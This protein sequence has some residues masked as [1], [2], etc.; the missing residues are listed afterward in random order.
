MKNAQNL[1]NRCEKNVNEK[2]A[3]EKGASL[4]GS[5]GLTFVIV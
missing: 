2:D 1:I 3:D 5:Y 4:V